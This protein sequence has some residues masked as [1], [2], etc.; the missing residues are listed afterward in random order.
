LNN[1][2]STRF[3][4]EAA[5]EA[6]DCCWICGG[7]DLTPV[8]ELL[9]ELEEYRRQDP[10]LA[11]YSGVR[12]SLQRCGGCG[13]AQPAALPALSGYF[14]RLYDQRWSEDWIR[15]EFEAPT[16]DA[17]FS[18][19]LGALEARLPPGRRRLLDV[20]TH[21]GR[22]L[23]M[24]RS[25]GWHAAGLELNPK[26]AAFAA[27]ASGAAVHQGNI[28][29]SALGDASFDAI[30]LTD[31]FEH[32][33]RPLEVLRRVRQLVADDGWIAIKVPNGPA[34]RRKEE[35][36]ARLMRAY[37]ATLADNLVHVNHFSPR[38]LRLA[39]Q[40]S[41]FTDVRVHVGAPELPPESSAS[42]RIGR[43]IVFHAAR[44]TGGAASPL[45]LNLQA[46]A[47]RDRGAQA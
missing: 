12:L 30:A 37:R 35:M 44:L 15:A 7:R 1:H 8:H 38:S 10:E 24:A 34:Q 45:A 18:Q 6:I 28:H 17:I 47:R 19:I 39:L 9:F 20:G 25:R 3:S 33:P 16:K 26:T 41:G 22:F 27:R 42:S 11:A 23:T 29:S 31:V 36:R 4:A 14:D 43:R 32:V 46:Y 2:G 40:R 21:A 13:F 5:F